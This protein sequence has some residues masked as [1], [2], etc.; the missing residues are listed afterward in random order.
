MGGIGHCISSEKG[1]IK[2]LLFSA[3]RSQLS[4]S[5]ARHPGRCFGRPVDRWIRKNQIEKR[6]RHAS[7]K[8]PKISERSSDPAGPM[9]IPAGKDFFSEAP[10]C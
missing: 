4:L 5:H 7:P 10:K 9:G 6:T 1:E 3:L 2:E 8:S